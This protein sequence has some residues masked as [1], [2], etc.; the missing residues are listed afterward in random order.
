MCK[1]VISIQINRIIK[2]GFDLKWNFDKLCCIA[3]MEKE[4]NINS[5]STSCNRCE[6]PNCSY[7]ECGHKL[8]LPCIKT[9]FLPLY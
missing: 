6:S 5:S 7:L 9:Y 2:R 3:C 4:L 1:E 8:C